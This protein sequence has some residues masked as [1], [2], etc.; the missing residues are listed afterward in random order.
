MHNTLHFNTSQIELEGP[1]KSFLFPLFPT[2]EGSKV[3]STPTHDPE[4]ESFIK[5]ILVYTCIWVYLFKLD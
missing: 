1:L 2:A 4:V 5:V 3:L